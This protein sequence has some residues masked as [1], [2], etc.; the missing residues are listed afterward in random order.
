MRKDMA[1]TLL[2][3]LPEQE[4]N[5]IE[6][7]NGRWVAVCPF[8]EG[9][10][11]PSL[12][13]YTHNDT[14]YCFGCGAWGDPVKF[15]C[16]YKG[17]DT[18][19]A[20]EYVGVDYEYKKAEKANVIKTRDTVRTWE[21]LDGVSQLYYANL[22]RT[23]GAWNYLKRRGLS[24]DTIRIRRIGY[25][26]G[27]TLHIENTTDFRLAHECGLINNQGY[28]T[29]SHRI[30][31]PNFCG[32]GRVDFIMGRTVTND[33]IKYLG[34]RMPKP[35]YGFNSV[36]KS[37]ILFLSEGQFDWL[38]L[39]QWGYPAIVL[40]GSNLARYHFIALKDKMVIIVPDNDDVGKASAKKL[41]ASLP[42]SH[43][44]D[45]SA[46]GAK[47]VGELGEKGGENEFAEIIR[48]Q[49]WYQNIRSS[50]G[51]HWM[52]WFPSLLQTESLESTLKLQV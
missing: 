20:Q 13:I 49:E 52:K 1:K 35:I 19:R 22:L 18:K 10:R 5:L 6:S 9:D 16:D 43:I 27:R 34:T 37:P 2:E 46:L 14:Y 42:N 41:H 33:R 8:H 31:I 44:L 17:W 24:D 12:T 11:D 51:D 40:S 29:M 3:V 15:L 28:E 26:D 23:E 25:T 21:F 47:D 45:Y 50:K 39:S 30:T 7:S 36:A 38:I 4:I 48:E 32:P